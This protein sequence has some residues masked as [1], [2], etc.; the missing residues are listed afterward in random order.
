MEFTRRVRTSLMGAALSILLLGTVTAKDGRDFAGSYGVTNVQEQGDVVH[1]MLH[2]RLYNNSDADIK[3]AV[4]ILREGPTGVSLR[5]S[6]PTVKVWQK[7]HGVQL[8]QEFTVPKRE[9]EDWMQ[10]PAQP[11]VVVIFQDASGHTWQRTAQ[12][13][14]EPTL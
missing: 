5:G 7:S 6:F 1:L 9:Y 12:L 3:G 11:N 14:P 8:S 13:A 10:P 2:V 4:V